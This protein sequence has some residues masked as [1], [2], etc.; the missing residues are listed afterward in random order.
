M[1]IEVRRELGREVEENATVGKCG[2]KEKGNWDWV[3]EM[4]IDW[5]K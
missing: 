1:E 4:G 5:K 3:V 2:L